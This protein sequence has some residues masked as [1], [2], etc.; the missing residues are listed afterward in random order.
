MENQK[1]VSQVETNN[2]VILHSNRMDIVQ[3]FKNSDKDKASFICN[4]KALK[5]ELKKISGLIT[6]KAPLPILEYFKVNVLKGRVVFHASNLENC[7]KVT[8][9]CETIGTGKFCISAKLLMEYLTTI[10]DC[11][12]IIAAKFSKEEVIE[13]D[14]KGEAKEI[15]TIEN[16]V[17]QIGRNGGNLATW[18]GESTDDYPIWKSPKIKRK[19]I[20]INSNFLKEGLERTIKYCGK[21]DLRPAMTGI[22]IEVE[23]ETIKF[24]STDA[25]KL[26]VQILHK[27]ERNFKTFGFDKTSFIIP[28]SGAKIL[29]N[30]FKSSNV[31]TEMYLYKNS[32]TVS[33]D[34]VRFKI[35]LIDDKYPNY[36]AVIPSD[37][38]KI[39]YVN[40]KE[41]ISALKMV[42]ISTNKATNQ[43][44]FALNRVCELTAQDLDFNLEQKEFVK[45]FCFSQNELFEIAFNGKFLTEILS[46]I[47]TEYVN[48]EMSKPNRAALVVPVE[49]NRHTLN[50]N[51]LMP[52][53]INS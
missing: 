35:R 20:E 24:V 15:N 13:R 17:I 3:N 9:D 22:N 52:V 11:N 51:L 42:A 19:T 6:N 8:I 34:N 39:L 37:N 16:V 31:L 7:G 53:L 32:L 14:D 28:Q 46:D 2:K 27:R 45:D 23:N 18:Q 44:R 4:S 30:C 21:D 40:R 47:S 25:H 5:N 33:F 36:N 50:M 1:E 43:I 12:I 48:I 29:I 49:L 10:Q 38:D 26:A 41:L